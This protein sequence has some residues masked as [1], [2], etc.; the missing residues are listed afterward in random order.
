MI[1]WKPTIKNP[2]LPKLFYNPLKPFIIQ[3]LFYKSSLINPRLQ[4]LLYILFTNSLLQTLYYKSSFTNPLL[5]PL[6]QTLFY[7]I[8]IPPSLS[9]IISKSSFFPINIM[10]NFKKKNNSPFTFLLTK[11]NRFDQGQLSARNI[12]IRIYADIIYLIKYL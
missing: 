6:L 12:F 8:F 10:T 2:F 11:Y 9:Q 7:K 4:T 5:R 3:T 1:F